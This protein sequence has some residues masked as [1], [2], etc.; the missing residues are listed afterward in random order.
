MPALLRN[1]KCMRLYAVLLFLD[2][3]EWVE[4]VG[5]AGQVEWIEANTTV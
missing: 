4:W 5:A 1:P 3:L 2:S